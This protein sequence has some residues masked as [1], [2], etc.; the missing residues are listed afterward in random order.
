[1]P[2]RIYIL[3]GEAS[4]DLHA[5]NLIR[6]LLLQDPT[7][8]IR[9]WGGDLMEEAG[10]Q[11]VKHYRDLAF[12]GFVEVIRNLPTIFGNLRFAKRDMEAFQPD[13]VIFVDYPG[14]NLRLV[15]WVKSRGFRTIYYIS[16]Q[17]WAWHKSRIK[18]IR[19]EVDDLLVILPFEEEFFAKEGVTAHFVG[20]PLVEV[21]Q[22]FRPTL[23]I[24][25]HLDLPSDQPLVALLPGSRR[26]EV[27][28]ML[29]I[30]AAM[31]RKYPAF[32]WVIAEAPGLSSDTYSRILQQYPSLKSVRGKT[33]DL[34]AAAHAAIVTSG[35]ATL[36]TALFNVPQVVAYKGSA[37]SFWI[38]KRLVKLSFISLVNLLLDRK[39]VTELI[40]N[41]L[42][43]P[44]L[45]AAFNNLLEEGPRAEMLAGYEELQSRL[46]Q[47]PASQTAARHILEVVPVRK[48]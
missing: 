12:M 48:E 36:E 23:D 33:Y 31:A 6:A 38:A 7:L 43:L 2:R 3:A 35:T 32:A 18:I 37:I 26:Q 40:Q 45:E 19:K 42:N 13:A 15:P 47:K 44:K 1:M 25:D 34:L 28:N 4:G 22:Q 46:G 41:D 17:L 14:F 27:E 8:T 5:S 30:M 21:V 29:P 9:G 24:R 11:V 16:P 39:L 10:C 20:H